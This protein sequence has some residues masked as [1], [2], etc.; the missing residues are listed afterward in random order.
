MTVDE[1]DELLR[2]SEPDTNECPTCE[3]EGE[4]F[5]EAC[6]HTNTCGDCEGSGELE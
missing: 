3:G 1:D 6:E 2:N 5:C 4:I